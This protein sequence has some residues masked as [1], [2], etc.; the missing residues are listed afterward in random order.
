MTQ[1]MI[2]IPQ[3]QIP[4][5]LRE[6]HKCSPEE[7]EYIDRAAMHASAVASLEPDYAENYGRRI[8]RKFMTERNNRFASFA[9]G[10]SLYHPESILNRIANGKDEPFNREQLPEDE[11]MQEYS[12]QESARI[13]HNRAHIAFLG[14]L[15]IDKRDVFEAEE[16]SIAIQGE[17]F[18]TILAEIIS[19]PKRGEEEVAQINYRDIA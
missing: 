2:H 3:I 19:L 18:G 17:R 16:K 9:I 15:M 6:S 10:A 14:N 4:H 7:L 13:F 8:A 11:A 1:T 12:R 5:E